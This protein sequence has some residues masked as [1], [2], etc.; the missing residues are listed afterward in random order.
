VVC[1][2][3]EAVACTPVS[4]PAKVQKALGLWTAANSASRTLALFDVTSSMTRFMAS[5]GTSRAPLSR[6]PPSDDEQPET[7]IPTPVGNRA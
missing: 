5:T 3:G 1:K 7:R 4:D 6:G 2:T